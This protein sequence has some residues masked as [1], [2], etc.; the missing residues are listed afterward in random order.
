MTQTG[1]DL[2]VIVV[3]YNVEH[4]LAQCLTSVSRAVADA[5]RHGYRCEVVVVDLSLI[6]I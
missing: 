3:N 5:E 1:M 6:H 4:F 2:S